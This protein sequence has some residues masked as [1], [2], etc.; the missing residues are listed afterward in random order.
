MLTE[1]YMI[2]WIFWPLTTLLSILMP[3]QEAKAQDETQKVI[4]VNLDV[5]NP[6]DAGKCYSTTFDKGKVELTVGEEDPL[7]VLTDYSLEEDELK[8]PDCFMPEVKLIYERYTYVVSLY[9]TCA[10]KYKN[11]APWVPS[12]TLATNDLQ[13]TETVLRVLQGLRKKHFNA[14][15]NAKYASVYVK[16]EPFTPLDTKVDD[17]IL[18]EDRED[19]GDLQNEAVDKEGW[20]EDESPEQVKK[21]IEGD[22]QTG[23]DE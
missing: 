15:T 19:D 13:M 3:T 22:F 17:V 21:K 18:P 20:F 6:A 10:K 11:S 9:C 16:K 14:T 7:A 1:R 23:D 8:G 5:A 2:G 4:V 12:S